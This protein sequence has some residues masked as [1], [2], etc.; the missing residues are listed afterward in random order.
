MIAD[1][2][3]LTIRRDFARVD[4]HHV[5]RFAGAQT[6]HVVDAMDGHG[7][8]DYRIKPLDPEV[9]SFAG[10]ALTCHAGADDNLAILAAFASARPGDVIVAACDGFTGSAVFGDLFARYARNCE[11]AAVI[12]D[13]LARD[14]AGIIATGLPVFVGGVTPGSSAR[15]GPGTIGLPVVIGHISIAPGDLIVGDRDGVVVVPRAEVALVATRLD[16]V[17]SAESIF[18][19][20]ALTGLRVPDFMRSLLQSDNVQYVD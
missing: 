9:A 4:P 11:V 14:A 5:A 16:A 15:S 1:P 17:R 19:A 13:G 10:P 3:I 12:T 18:E 2:P 20:D 6:V 8:L 7:A